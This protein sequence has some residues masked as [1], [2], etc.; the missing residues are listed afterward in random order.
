MKKRSDHPPRIAQRF[1]RWFCREEHLEVLLGDLEELFHQRIKTESRLSAQFAYFKDVLSLFR[2]F[3]FKKIKSP[4]ILKQR[5]MLWNNLKIA[6]R[7]LLKNRLQSG[8]NILG[9]SIGVA[10]FLLLLQYV[11]FEKSYDTWHENYQDIYRLR[12][13]RIYEDK[14]DKSAGITPFVGPYLAA[15]F[16]E[17]QAYTKLWS[18]DNSIIKY[19]DKAF[20]QDRIYYADSS[21]FSVFS[22]PMLQGEPTTCLND[23]NTVVLTASTARK[24][25][26]TEDPIGKSIQY[27]NNGTL[28]D[29][30]VT[31]VTADCPDNT[32]LKFEMLFSFKTLVQATEGRAHDFNKGWNAFL[33]YLRFQPQTNIPAFEKK[34]AQFTASN[35]AWLKE[36]N[37]TAHLLLQP[38]ASI[39]LHS[40]LRFEPET[41]G[42]HRLISFLYILAFCILGVGWFNYI[43][44]ATAKATERA[45]EVGIRKV[46][47]A[48]RFDLIWQFLT[49]SFVLNGVSILVAIVLLGLLHPTF[50]DLVEKEIPAQLLLVSGQWKLIMTVLLVGALLAGLYPAIVLAS[51]N[52]VQAFNDQ[53]QRIQGINLRNV[54][55]VF[56]FAASV[57]LI[58]GT[59]VVSKQLRFMRSQD[60]GVN[61]DRVLVLNGPDFIDSTYTTRFESFKQ[62]VQSLSDVQIITNA[63]TIPGREIGWVNNNVRWAKKPA[64]EPNSVP[65][66]AVG[67]DFFETFGLSLVAGRFFEQDYGLDSNKIILTETTV[68]KFGFNSPE[69]A[70]NEQIIDGDQRYEVI[71]VTEDFNQQALNLEYLPVNF[72]YFPNVSNYYAIKLNTDNYQ[73]A[74]T[75]IENHWEVQFPGNPFDHFFMDEFFNQQYKADQRFGKVFGIFSVLAMLIALMGLFGLSTLVIA[76]RTKEIGIR[77]VL[78][79]SVW[80]LFMHLSKDHLKLVA[81]A[82]VVACPLIFYLSSL[83]LNNYA[84]RIDIQWWMFVLPAIIVT[85]IALV[86]MAFRSAKAARANPVEA[87][88]YE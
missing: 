9:L 42:N 41:N 60:L 62:E 66:V 81:I 77:K 4:N 17:I 11:H 80:N 45:K 53:W 24:Y 64:N 82:S 39:H 50:N 5:D 75:Q 1:L 52:P 35:Y 65:F 32:H 20:R 46:N 21:F 57:I 48:Q 2:P 26:G 58:A 44:L 30:T 78:G 33:T 43:N 71:G 36:R 6:W 56:Q 61:L 15:E 47:G 38:V 28:R 83:W 14:H 13:D 3:A 29:Y 73:R 79:A 31:G 84:F 37:V 88:K 68:N 34:L 72:I 54:L 23:L 40:N 63:T 85:L 10:V 87:L 18:V 70:I 86:T 22:Y 27:N 19:K 12:F 67:S 7:N 16:P 8:I 69:E 74:I 55:I 51:F 49:E 76:R 25:F 59:L